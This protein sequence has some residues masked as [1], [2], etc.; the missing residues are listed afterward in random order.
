L[1][2]I[3]AGNSWQWQQY[4]CI[5]RHTH[6]ICMSGWFVEIEHRVVYSKKSAI[7]WYEFRGRRLLPDLAI[8]DI[9]FPRRHCQLAKEWFKC[10]P[11]KSGASRGCSHPLQ[12]LQWPV[13]LVLPRYRRGCRN[14]RILAR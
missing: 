11:Y 13:G 1:V 4:K 14:S 9:I 2:T 3:L 5:Y 12:R 10:L 7:H 6:V 8:A